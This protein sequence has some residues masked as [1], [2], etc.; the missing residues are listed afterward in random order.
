MRVSAGSYQG[1]F[2]ITRPVRIVGR[3]AE[4]TTLWVDG[5]NLALGDGVPAFDHLRQSALQLNP[6]VKPL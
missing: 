2:V 3:C 5:F 1:P 4:K 6:E